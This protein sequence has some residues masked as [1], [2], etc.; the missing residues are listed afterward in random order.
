MAPVTDFNYAGLFY[1]ADSGLSLTQYR[2]YDPVTGRWLSLDPLG[3][4]GDPAGNLYAYVRR[5]PAVLADRRG[6]L[7]NPLPNPNTRPPCPGGN[8]PIVPVNAVPPPALSPLDQ[9]QRQTDNLPNIL[10]VPVTPNVYA[11]ILT[12]TVGGAAIGGVAGALQ[13]FE[14]G[15]G[16]PLGGLPGAALLGIGGAVGGGILGAG[17]GGLAGS[18]LDATGLGYT[19]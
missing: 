5:D 19:R 17:L 16:F 7:A 2:A 3:E 14:E 10:G 9:L 6:L 15:I 12:G 1:N 8:S 18:G 11:G 4:D 13:G